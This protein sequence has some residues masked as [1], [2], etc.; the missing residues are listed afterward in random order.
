MYRFEVNKVIGGQLSIVKFMG[1]WRNHE[2][3]RAGLCAVRNGQEQWFALLGRLQIQGTDGLLESN[4]DS[5]TSAGRREC[6]L[7]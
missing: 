3:F 2:C 1:Q 5:V 6:R 7:G 4:T